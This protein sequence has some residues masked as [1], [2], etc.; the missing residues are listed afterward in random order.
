MFLLEKEAGISYYFYYA[1]IANH[2]AMQKET[3][4]MLEIF[5]PNL[6]QYHT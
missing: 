2:S 4:K 1:M 5:Y 3:L 6:F